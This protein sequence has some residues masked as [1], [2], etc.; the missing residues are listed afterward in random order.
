MLDYC[1]IFKRNLID[2]LVYYIIQSVP[3]H[4]GLSLHLKDKNTHIILEKPRI[5]RENRN[6]EPITIRFDVG[7]P[8]L[9]FFKYK[10]K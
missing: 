2:L 3:Y 1:G 8:V 5:S 7:H 4:I 9:T 10:Q 6:L